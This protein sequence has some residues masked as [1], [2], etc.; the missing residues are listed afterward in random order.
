MSHPED[1]DPGDK[2]NL[3]GKSN[4]ELHAWLTQYKPG[5]DEYDA[6][7]HESMRR[8]ASIEEMIEKTEEPARHREMIA[9]AIAA[10]ALVVAIIVITLSY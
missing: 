8:V 10:I 3:K 4:D 6:G 1:K 2:F 5:S 9:L 7:L